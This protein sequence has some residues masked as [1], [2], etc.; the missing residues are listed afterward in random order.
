MSQLHFQ[1]RG[2]ETIDQKQVRLTRLKEKTAKLSVPELSE[3]SRELR[4]RFEVLNEEMDVL[5][6]ELEVPGR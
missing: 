6:E 5:N 4:T 1:T 2:D 3:L